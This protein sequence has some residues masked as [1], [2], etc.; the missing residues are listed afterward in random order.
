MYILNF[1]EGTDEYEQ[2]ISTLSID[3]HIDWV[4]EILAGIEHNNESYI[5]IHF[6]SWVEEK[7]EYVD[8]N[9]EIYKCDEEF[10]HELESIF[11]EY[12]IIDNVVISYV[13]DIDKGDIYPDRLINYLYD[14]TDEDRKYIS[15]KVLLEI[16]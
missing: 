1:S 13:F 8:I 11:G 14:I 7:Q 9:I 6:N 10:L 2:S 4:Y 16:L 3:N 5:H 12:T 15:K